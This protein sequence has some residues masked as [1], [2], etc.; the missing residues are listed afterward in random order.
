MNDHLLKKCLKKI[1]QKLSWIDSNHWQQKHFEALSELI[2]EK[3]KINLS[4]L[5][6][7]RLWGKT[8]YNS[9]PST[10]TLDTLAL[11]LDYKDW[12]DYQNNQQKSVFNLKLFFLANKKTVV[13]ASLILTAFALFG[14]SM[15]YTA[16]FKTK[17]YSDF[18][19]SIQKLSS[20]VPNT[21]YFKYNV[22]NTDADS[23]IIQQSW[24]PKLHHLVDKN[25]TDFSCIYYYPGYYKAK[26]VLDKKVVCHQDLYITSNGWLGIINKE[27]VPFYLTANEI[28]DGNIL[29]I[30][31]NQ[32]I[33]A[34]FDLKNKIPFTTINLVENFDSI[35]GN[36]FE[37]DARFKQTY[38]KG[39]AICQKAALM[40]SCSNGYFYIP[41]S[42]KGCVNEL[43]MHIPN[44]TLRAE[45]SDLRIL[46]VGNTET[47][48]LKLK[49][50]HGIFDL[51]V[52]T[53]PNVND[54]LT[55][56][57]GKIV[58]VRFEFHGTGEVYDFN[59]RDSKTE[60][61]MNDFMP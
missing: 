10:T 50:S 16:R 26:L 54:T 39:E 15:K 46:G 32:L 3:T 56:N 37:L 21:V 42:I 61:S 8:N 17:D 36:N 13:Y 18:E 14:A 31:E 28:I 9:K 11:F 47:I 7:K 45:D 23:V 51:A 60:Y 24:D 41:F 52:N 30:T 1:E 33:E 29:L 5:T 22:K 49:V 55:T 44:K 6:L 43:K 53:N 34:G 35:K 20:G 40:I 25:K 59:I 2:Y 57:P 48:D 58:G 27:T 12:I 38:S 4:P 19:F